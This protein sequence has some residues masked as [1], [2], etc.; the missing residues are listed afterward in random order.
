MLCL[1]FTDVTG[2]VQQSLGGLTKH[3]TVC[4]GAEGEYRFLRWL[5]HSWPH[6]ERTEGNDTNTVTRSLQSWMCDSLAFFLS[7]YVT[8]ITFSQ[9]LHTEWFYQASCVSSKC[10]SRKIQI[11]FIRDRPIWLFQGRYRY[12]LLVIKETDNRY[13]EPIYICSKIRTSW[14]QNVE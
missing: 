6:S 3:S 1:D 8:C 13:L 2:V 9:R 7:F 10:C 12:R 11:P 5:Q 4:L 14:C